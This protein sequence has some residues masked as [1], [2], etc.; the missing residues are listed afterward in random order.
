MLSPSTAL[1]CT[2]RDSEKSP[3]RYLRVYRLSSERQAVSHS[4]IAHLA[5][6]FHVIIPNEEAVPAAL[7]V[8]RAARRLANGSRRDP[9]QGA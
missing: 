3:G 6:A 4:L 1:T 8:M 2:L 9:D 5:E 7:G